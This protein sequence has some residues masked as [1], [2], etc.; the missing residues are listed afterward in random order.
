MFRLATLAVANRDG[1]VSRVAVSTAAHRNNRTATT[2]DDAVL[3]DA[4][5][6]LLVFADTL[7]EAPPSKGFPVRLL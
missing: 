4:A 1:G 3:E 6:E 7:P 5:R 2:A